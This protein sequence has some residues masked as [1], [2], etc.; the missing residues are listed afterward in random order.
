MKRFY[1]LILLVIAFQ[2]TRGQEKM[3][4]D[5]DRNYFLI[6]AGYH[7]TNASNKGLNFVIDRYNQTRQGQQGAA[8]LTKNMDYLKNMSGPAFGL[9]L[10]DNKYL[11]G[12][13]FDMNISLLNSKAG[14]EGVDIQGNA[15]SRDLQ[16][17]FFYWN[18]DFGYMFFQSQIIDVG[19]AAGTSLMFGN[20]DTR[21]GTNAFENV[22]E[23][24]AGAFEIAPQINFFLS[25]SVPFSLSVRPYY[26][27]DILPSEFDNL[28]EKINPATYENDPEQSQRGRFNHMGAQVRLNLMIRG[29]KQEGA[30]EIKGKSKTKKGTRGFEN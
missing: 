28:N 16:M 17:K 30:R 13:F 4:Y 11:N 6:G 27:L 15:A 22:D 29:A 20:I 7:L 25:K 2:I 12:A 1:T 5:R 3:K 24:V 8:T 10:L 21:T 19:L 14:A 23:Y 18:F 26:Y 9:F